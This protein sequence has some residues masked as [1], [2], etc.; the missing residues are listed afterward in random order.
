MKFDSRLLS[1]V[2]VLA[3]VV[4]TGSF[5]RAGE[6]IGIT[7]SGVSRAV[8]RLEDRIGVKL[9]QRT[10]RSVALTEEG[11]QFYEAVSPLLSGIEDAAITAAGA[12]SVVRGRLRVNV[13]GA[14][15]GYVL[16]PAMSPF[17]EQH[18]ALTVELG[19][20][21]RMGDLVA[22]GFDVAVRFGEPEPS[23]LSSK[24]LL[25]TRVLTCA[26]PEYVSRMGM[27]STPHE[28]AKDH[29][30][31]LLR[32]PTSGTPFSWEFHRGEE[33]VV[34]NAHGG[35]VVNDTSALMGACLGGQAIAQPL[36]LYAR[37]YIRSGQ[38]VQL[39][40]DWADE[41]FPLYMYYRPHKPLP[42]K[43]RVFLAYIEA[44]TARINQDNS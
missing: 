30:C 23:A 4:E 29:Q 17:L 43:V 20:R 34:V 25:R 39:V 21:D 38:L 10:A 3:A 41:R 15:G 22:E 31:V 27:P 7:Q 8:A 28:L 33:R 5:V 42:A 12:A 40:P 35:L 19:V 26:S 18:S 16:A 44:L 14:F 36:E 11:R 37:Q 13:D 6:A 24:L 32:D 2:G 9:F 1:G